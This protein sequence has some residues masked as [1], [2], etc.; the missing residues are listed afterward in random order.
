M[1]GLSSGRR[2]LLVRAVQNT[3]WRQLL[4]FVSPSLFD[5]MPMRELLAQGRELG[6]NAAGRSFAGVRERAQARLDTADLAVR[7]E[8]NRSLE[9]PVPSLRRAL[10]QRALEVYFAQLLRGDEALLDLRF[11]CW[12]QREPEAAPVWAP[13]PLWLSWDPE[14]LGGVRDLY[15]GFYRDDDGAYARGVERLGLGDAGALLR[16]HFGEGDQRAVRFDSAA[17]QGTF[18]QVFVRCRDQGIS[19]HRNFLALGVYLATLYDLLEGLDEAF[20]VRDAFE[21]AAP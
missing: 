19:L 8:P 16:Q 14:F 10:G 15:A 7:L 18:H 2:A 4:D 6:A 17:F 9:P 21:R 12:T 1:L 11:A 5:V 20:D 13:R 3:E